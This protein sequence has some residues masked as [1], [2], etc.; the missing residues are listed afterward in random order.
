MMHRQAMK[1]LLLSGTLAA[2]LALGAGGFAQRRDRWP[3]R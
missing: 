2:A 1:S 3:T